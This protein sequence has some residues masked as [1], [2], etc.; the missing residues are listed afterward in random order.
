MFSIPANEVDNMIDILFYRDHP[1]ITE[2]KLNQ[3]SFRE[4]E[5]SKKTLNEFANFLQLYTQN[6]KIPLF[7][8]N[9]LGLIRHSF[10]RQIDGNLLRKLYSKTNTLEIS[11]IS[12][13]KNHTFSLQFDQNWKLIDDQQSNL[14]VDRS[15]Q[16]I[17]KI[18]RFTVGLNNTSPNVTKAEFSTALQNLPLFNY[19]ASLENND[20]F[21]VLLRLKRIRYK[22]ISI[23]KPS[24]HISLKLEI[25]N[26]LL[27]T[28]ISI[29][30]QSLSQSFETKPPKQIQSKVNI[31]NF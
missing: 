2:I 11:Y 27:Y 24:T 30:E 8:Q 28:F 23:F 4:L 5:L 13:F 1:I 3:K 16:R 6:R 31:D 18:C 21:N 17:P 25:N 20:L 7:K 10:E 14:L 15:S 19:L 29:P 9:L 26:E 12:G 22:V